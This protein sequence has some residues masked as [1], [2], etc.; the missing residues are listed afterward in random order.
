MNTVFVNNI[1]FDL[2]KINRSDGEYIEVECSFLY[3]D[4]KEMQWKQLYEDISRTAW[5]HNKLSVKLAIPHLN[6]SG[7][8]GVIQIYYVKYEEKMVFSVRV[9][10]QNPDEI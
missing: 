5:I 1:E 8:F 2:E 6:I 9:E 4:E 7:I 3:G 10:K